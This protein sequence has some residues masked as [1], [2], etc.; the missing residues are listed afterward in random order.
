MSNPI[1]IYVLNDFLKFERKLYSLFGVN[2][3]RSIQFKT[4]TY[5]V[6]AFALIF[7]LSLIPILGAPLAA[8]PILV[9]VGIAG[10]IA[11]LLTDVGTENRPPL[12]AFASFVRYHFQIS[13]KQSYYRG[14]ILTAPQPVKF[15]TTI[16]VQT[17]TLMKLPAPAVDNSKPPEEPPPPEEKTELLMIEHHPVIK[18]KKG[19]TVQ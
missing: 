1:P 18:F 5:F 10:G 19:V 4:I 16:K 14:K 8:I 17:E 7:G 11:Y 9:K 13:K 3:G 12:N 15:G 6:A 2:L